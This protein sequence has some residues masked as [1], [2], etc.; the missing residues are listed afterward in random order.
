MA[1]E[2]MDRFRT[3]AEATG[4]TLNKLNPRQA[5]QPRTVDTVLAER[6]KW[7]GAFTGHAR[8]S[9]RLKNT[10]RAEAGWLKMDP[11][12]QE[13]LDMIQH[14]VARII[15]GDPGYL[16]SWVDIEGYTHLVVKRLEE[17]AL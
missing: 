2:P 9:Q 17:D 16:D 10:M 14:K 6:G 11:D 5:P 3:L 1:I 4:E 13:A 15:N 12:Q 8:I 7:Y